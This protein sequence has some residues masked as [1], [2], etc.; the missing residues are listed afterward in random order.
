[1]SQPRNTKAFIKEVAGF[2]R[3]NNGKEKLLSA[4]EKV[5]GEVEV[6][7]PLTLEKLLSVFGATVLLFPPDV[8]RDKPLRVGRTTTI[9]ERESWLKALENLDKLIENPALQTA[10]EDKKREFGLVEPDENSTLCVKNEMLETVTTVELF[11]ED[12]ALRVNLLLTEI[13]TGQAILETLTVTPHLL[14]LGEQIGEKIEV[15]EF[16]L[17]IEEKINPFVNAE[18]P[19]E[20]PTLENRRTSSIATETLLKKDFL[21]VS[22]S[23]SYQAMREVVALKKFTQD[24]ESPYPTAYVEK[25]TIKGKIQ[26]TP[27]QK[28]T[29]SGEKLKELEAS[30]WRKREQLSDLHVDVIDA[31]C[32]TWIIQAGSPDSKAVITADDILKLRGLKPHLSGNGRRGGFTAEQRSEIIEA[33]QDLENVWFEITEKV[34]RGKKDKTDFIQSRAVVVLDRGGQ[35][36]LDGSLDVTWFIFRPGTIFAKYLLTEGRQT[37]LLS[38]HALRYHVKAEAVEKR[39]AR[40][41]S[42]QWRIRS[43]TTT[44]LQPYEVGTL[45]KEAGIVIR[46]LKPSRLSERLEKALD[47]LQADGLIA[48]WQYSNW[49]WAKAKK[50]GW[51]NDWLSAKIAIEP[52][53]FIKDSYQIIQQPANLKTISAKSSQTDVSEP[54][55]TSGAET[56]KVF[57]R[58]EIEL[59][60]QVK[61]KRKLMKLTQMQLAEQLNLSQATMAR[62]EGKQKISDEAKQKVLAWLK[63]ETE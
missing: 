27:L 17:R 32:A 53:E 20:N 14:K 35:L 15:L 57:P 30:M 31:I 1:M 48:A 23:A 50:H 55:N 22:S 46:Q 6:K 54:T 8:E 61:A 36:N 18:Q 56:K 51:L 62:V 33:I 60:H 13:E 10:I 11:A 21:P 9:K 58:N 45:V 39:L 7:P 19:P 44:Y 26:L 59:A 16:I 3:T 34:K 43:K 41:F 5:S 52:P 24:V 49:D 25:A 2:I 47:K 29:V 63:L 12:L 37:A 4:L 28:E 40:Y 38:A 42:W